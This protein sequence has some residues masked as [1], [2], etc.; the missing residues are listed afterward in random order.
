MGGDR[1]ARDEC[2]AVLRAFFAAGGRVVDSSPMYG[3]AEAVVGALLDSLRPLPAEPLLASKVWTRG[4]REGEEG[5]GTS[6]S[7]MG[8]ARGG[9]T[10][11]GWRSYP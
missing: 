4:R 9:R 10:P 11:D 7:R 5:L 6:L 3:R 2:I 8:G 1:T